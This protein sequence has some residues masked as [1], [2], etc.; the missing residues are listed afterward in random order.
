MSFG[1]VVLDIRHLLP[2]KGLVIGEGKA[3]DLFVSSDGLPASEFPLIRCEGGRFVLTF[4]AH[5]RGEIALTGMFHPLAWFTHH[6]GVSPDPQLEGCYR[7]VLPEDAVATLRFEGL[8]IVLRQ[9]TAPE[10]L[11][12]HPTR[13]DLRYGAMLLAA[14]LCVL[15]GLLGF[16]LIGQSPE[17]ITPLEIPAISAR[18][19]RL[20]TPQASVMTGGESEKRPGVSLARPP[21]VLG[22]LSSDDAERA[23][24]PAQAAVGTCLAP[25]A[26]ATPVRARVLVDAD[27]TGFVSSIDVQTDDAALADRAGDCL[28]GALT[29]LRFAPPLGGQAEVDYALEARR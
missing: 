14:S 3:A 18:T 17:Q 29:Q 9:V 6:T 7:Y 12:E 2:P 24:L 1:E 8:T 27:G 19:A 13:R 20:L 4:T 23:L 25:L 11:E 22:V 5:Q 15:V 16:A 10:R 26:A 21:L 28:Y